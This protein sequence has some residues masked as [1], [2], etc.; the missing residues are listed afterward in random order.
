[1]PAASGPSLRYETTHAER[2]DRLASLQAT[3]PGVFVLAVHSFVEGVI[4]ERITLEPGDPEWFS[5][6]VD[7]YGTYCQKKLGG[8][9]PSLAVLGLLRNAHEPTNAV[10][11]NFAAMD[12]TRAREATQHLRRFCQVSGI[13]CPQ[14]LARLERYLLAW[15]ERKPAGA[16]REELEAIRRS[17]GA[18][19]ASGSG[20]HE[21]IAELDRAEREARHYREEL[22]VRERRIEELTRLAAD[23]DGK[24]DGLRDERNKFKDEVRRLKAE[25]DGLAASLREAEER[26]AKE[27]EARAYREA[28]LAATTY[29]RTRADYERT[30]IRL[31][32]E[33]KAV[34]RQIRLDTDFLVKGAAG[35]GKTLVLLEAVRKAKGQGDQAELGLEELS[36]SIALLTY[37]RALTKYDRYLARL[38]DLDAG[39][40]IQTALSFLTE[41][42]H[43]LAPGATVELRLQDEDAAPFCPGFMTPREFAAEADNFIWANLMTEE[44]Y[45]AESFPRRGMRKPLQPRQREVVWLAVEALEAEL[46]GKRRSTQN[47]AARDLVF[48]SR[49]GTSF[50]DVDH[51]FVDETQDLSAA[52]LAAIKASSRRSL[53]LAGDGDQSIYQPFTSFER[54]G[55][56]IIG[57]TRALHTNFRNTVQLHDYAERYRALGAAK[58]ASID[59]G[60]QPEA[61]RE[62]PE[63]ELFEGRD[64]GELLD[65]VA[66]HVGL[67]IGT[68]GYDPDNISILAPTNHDLDALAERLEA[69]G[70]AS[71]Q[72]H[73]DGFD[74]DDRGK[75]RL[76]TL[77]SAKGLDFPV[78]FL[79]IPKLHIADGSWESAA[80]D[81][82]NR[83]LLYVGLTRAMDHCAVFVKKGLET[84]AVKD[85]FAAKG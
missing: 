52:M 16:L 74:F 7:R 46:R 63:P 15:D 23:R 37:T 39:D 69:A 9:H 11:H 41:R 48:A 8:P 38:L 43:R 42:F 64:A 80:E 13:D 77:H 10:R 54:A 35:T 61:F 65:L 40:R 78:V 45:V 29:T 70:Y 76:C 44:E 85:L 67:Y 75:L 31:S 57:H 55:I 51:V 59:A 49:A 26:A 47:L 83:N 27:G 19:G 5:A 36:G 32:P 73:H 58:G 53:I 20:L 71:S 22:L 50:E 17:L 62:G 34:L 18:I 82:M 30:I 21:R 60:S 24:V 84:E 81:R 12:V 33:Q 14:E 4:R 3:D 6:L 66:S 68:L 2:L 28:L 79:W 25:R 1:M 56:D 72:V